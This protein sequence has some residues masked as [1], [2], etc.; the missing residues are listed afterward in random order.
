MNMNKI[1]FNPK[2]NFTAH[3]IDN[4]TVP[5][6]DRKQRKY[7]PSEI[8]IVEYDLGNQQD[9]EAIERAV[10]VWGKSDSFGSKIAEDAKKIREG[11][12]TR[13]K[14]KIYIAT[15]QHEN[16]DILDWRKIL[17]LS[18]VTC[19]SRKKAEIDYFQVSPTS[20]YNSDY[21]PYTNVG[22]SIM[23]LL[24]QIHRKRAIV[25]EVMY[26]AA[27]FYE[28]MG[29]VVIDPKKLIYMWKK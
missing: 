20:A 1:T 27:N 28:K 25:A 12:I 4:Y 5:E 15:S 10:K 26:S 24:K 6:F 18:S 2:L 3:Y 17:G 16:F 29:F 9:L 22:E 21:R 13:R 8:F 23:N 7:K 14:A 19:H 11:N